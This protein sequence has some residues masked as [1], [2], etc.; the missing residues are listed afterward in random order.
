MKKA[1]QILAIGAAAGA[2]GGVVETLPTVL[3]DPLSAP[4]TIAVVAMLG[5]VLP[6]PFQRRLPK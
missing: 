6:S 4:V 3:P 1:L 5:Y 2:V